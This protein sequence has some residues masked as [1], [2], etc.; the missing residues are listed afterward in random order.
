MLSDRKNLADSGVVTFTLEEDTQVRAISGHIFID[1]RG[2]VHAHE[3][4]KIHKEIVKS[5]RILYEQTIAKN[6]AIDRGGLV[7]ILRRE[8]GKL[9]FVLTGRTPIIM[10]IIIEK[11]IS[12]F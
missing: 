10:P 1:S 9:C 6:P 2:F 3:M 4:M 12:N 11:N 5:V 7:Q 8:I